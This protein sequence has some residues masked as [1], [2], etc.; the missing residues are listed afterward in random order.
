MHQ[1]HPWP[2]TCSAVLRYMPGEDKHTISDI[3]RALPAV[4]GAGFQAIHITAPYA[5]AGFHPWWGLRPADLTQPNQDLQGTMDDFCRLVHT[6]HR[7]GLKVLVFLN[8]GYTDINS[9]LWHEACQDV[10]QGIDSPAAGMFLWS[11]SPDTPLTQP[12]NAHFRQC[13]HWH[14]SDAAQKWYYCFWQMGDIAEPQYNYAS[15]HTQ[16]FIQS[17]LRHWLD[18][19]ID[20][21]IVDAVNWYINCT[22]EIMRRTITDVVHQYPGVVCL[23]E[24]GSGFGDGFA[25]WI[26]QGNFDIIDD[27]PFHSDLHWNGSAILRAL[28]ARDPEIL[29]AALETNRAARCMGIPAWS[30]PSWGDL[31]TPDLRLLEVA[32]LLGTGHM[33][34]IIPSYFSALD[35]ARTDALKQLLQLTAFPSLA[36]IA[37][38][39]RIPME[40][41]SACY[42]CLCGE[43][44][45]VLLQ[46]SNAPENVW[47]PLTGT[48]RDC[49]SGEVFSHRDTVPMA[50]A[51]YR[52]LVRI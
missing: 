29:H 10:R 2:C 21:V 6:A 5:S 14:W 19:G 38:R 47:F 48:W 16:Q 18:T 49:L 15:V 36:P 24:G 12:G 40:S 42:A 46:L 30:Y 17:V 50:A 32:A 27:Q 45:L 41:G 28:Q 26:Q 25:P 33:T 20:G 8:L 43:D 11:D 37:P 4:S 1:N 34:E 7:H 31:W 23:P 13:G 9:P 35:V 3:I 39:R 51:G 22:W 44:L 52:F